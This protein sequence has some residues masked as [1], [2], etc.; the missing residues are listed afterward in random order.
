MARSLS[1]S[2]TTARCASRCRGPRDVLGAGR[3][4]GRRR[5][6]RRRAVAVRR[7]RPPRD[8]SRPVHVDP[9]V[10]YE[11]FLGGTSGVPGTGGCAVDAAG[12][13]Y[14]TD[15]TSSATFPTTVGAYD[16]LLN[17]TGT[18]GASDGY[19]TKVNAA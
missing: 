6:A 12:A 17:L 14:L 3:V 15:T 16:T 9:T 18:V 4:A 19:L 10:A 8:P 7:R 5:R 13:A 11:S 1:A 2:P